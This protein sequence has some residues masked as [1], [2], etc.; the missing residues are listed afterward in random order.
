MESRRL[1]LVWTQ[2]AEQRYGETSIPGSEPNTDSPI[3]LQGHY[4]MKRRCQKKLS[5]SCFLTSKTCGQ[6]LILTIK[7]GRDA[8]S[9]VEQLSQLFSEELVTGRLAQFR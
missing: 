2:A 1:L 9:S 5:K 7:A 4:G 8:K 6:V 3:S